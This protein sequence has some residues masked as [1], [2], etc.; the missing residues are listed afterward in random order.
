MEDAVAKNEVVP[1]L[2]GASAEFKPKA[3]MLK[4]EVALVL[5]G[6]GVESEPKIAIQKH[7]PETLLRSRCTSPLATHGRARVR[8]HAPASHPQGRD[9]GLP[10]ATL[11]NGISTR[12]SEVSVWTSRLRAE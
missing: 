1:V 10:S 4:N 7:H 2:C 11:T 12:F 8:G 5:C 3:T 6:V 9:S